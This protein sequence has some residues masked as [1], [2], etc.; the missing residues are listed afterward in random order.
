MMDAPTTFEC[1]PFIV[2]WEFTMACNLRCRHCG[3]SAGLPRAGELTTE[4]ALRICDQFPALMVREVDF[5]GG[6]PLMRPDWPIVA[7][8]IV[9]L[10]I[11]ANILTNGL[12]LDAPLIAQMQDVGITG[13]GISL[14]GLV[15]RSA[16]NKV[17]C[18]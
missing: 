18:L 10:G 15:S 11:T 5:T 6:E 13:V 1:F 17:L 8:R 7:G 16:N 4:E 3:S 14:D 9:E 12:G 2:G